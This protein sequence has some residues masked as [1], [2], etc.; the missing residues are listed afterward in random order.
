MRLSLASTTTATVLLLAV[1][2]SAADQAGEV[3]YRRYCSACHGPDGKGD[4]VVSGLMT[5]KPTDLTQLT[6]ANDGKF[7]LL[8]VMQSID[9]RKKIA[10]HGD[11]DMPVW[12]EVFDKDRGQGIAAEA[13]VRGKVHEIATYVQSIQVK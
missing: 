10:A 2:A 5:P 12:G 13:Q 6:K 4:G 11:S 8:D 3:A 7:S 1:A 9:G